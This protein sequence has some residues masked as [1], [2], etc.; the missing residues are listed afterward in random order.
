[1]MSVDTV[2]ERVALEALERLLLT[3]EPRHLEDLATL[4]CCFRDLVT[5]LLAEALL[6]ETHEIRLSAI[7]TLARIDGETALGHIRQAAEDENQPEPVREFA[8][9]A[10]TVPSFE[11]P[12]PRAHAVG[13]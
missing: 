10:I 3:E 9:L 7:W 13:E 2:E 12:N 6:A 11:L 8:R 5:P 4:L 1:M